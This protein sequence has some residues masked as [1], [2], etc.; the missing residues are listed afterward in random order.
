M[1]LIVWRSRFLPLSPIYCDQNQWI[2]KLK[3]DRKIWMSCENFQCLKSEHFFFLCPFGIY[4]FHHCKFYY[5]H[6]IHYVHTGE[7]TWIHIT[8]EVDGLV[9][10]NRNSGCDESQKVQKVDGYEVLIVSVSPTIVEPLEIINGLQLCW[11]RWYRAIF[12][13]FSFATARVVLFDCIEAL[14]YTLGVEADRHFID[15]IQDIKYDLHLNY[16]A[17]IRTLW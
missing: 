2:Q 17:N 13:F 1:H 6:G 7:V 10:A 16:Q 8:C 14:I 3:D 9:L 12:V 11:N 15:I 4:L 5:E